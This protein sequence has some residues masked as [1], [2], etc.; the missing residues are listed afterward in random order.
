MNDVFC[1]TIEFET[2][3]RACAEAN[4]YQSAI[5]AARCRAGLLGVVAD[6]VKVDRG[7]RVGSITPVTS[8]KQ[9][10]RCSD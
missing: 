9:V 1:W 2:G 10:L 3:D 7:E 5:F 6:V 8:R 4:N